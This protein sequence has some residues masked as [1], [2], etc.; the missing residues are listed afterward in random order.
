MLESAPDMKI[1]D[2]LS[3]V[4]RLAAAMARAEEV[5]VDRLTQGGAARAEVRA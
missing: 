2:V 3:A 5:L 4:P 1:H